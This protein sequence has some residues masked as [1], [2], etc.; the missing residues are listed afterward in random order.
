MDHTDSLSLEARI[1]G[2]L[3]LAG[4]DGLSILQIQSV[5]DH[6]EQQEILDI[7][8]GLKADCANNR[9]G[10]MLERF[11]TRWKYL[12]KPD[13][14]PDA[15]RLY[16]QIKAPSISNAALETLSIIAYRQPITRAQIEE[17]RGVGCD[18]ILKKLS[19]RELIEAKERLDAIGK[20]LLYTVT[21]KFLETFGLESLQELPEIEDQDEMV[22]LFESTEE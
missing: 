14:Y 1:E 2:L 21:E 6:L 13:V 10:I 17:I 7:L 19:A 5:L 22:S 9:R 16:E 4:E 15:Q 12:T 18:A 8:L 11:G 20:P 3:F